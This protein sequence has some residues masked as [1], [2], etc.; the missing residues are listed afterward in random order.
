MTNVSN[1]I[2]PVTFYK[3]SKI[4][5]SHKRFV[6]DKIPTLH[7]K[8]GM[9]SKVLFERGSLKIT[10]SKIAA[11]GVE[12][13][14]NDTVWGAKGFKY[15]QLH[16]K[17]RIH[18]LKHPYHFSLNHGNRLL[19]NI[20]LD[21]RLAWM[22]KNRVNAYYIRY[23]AFRQQ[24][25][26][27]QETPKA[28]SKAGKLKGLLLNQM[29]SCPADSE[30]NYEED[31]TLPAITYGFVDGKN[32]RSFNQGGEFGF[33]TIRYFKPVVFFRYKPVSLKGVR[34]ITPREK[35]LIKQLVTASYA[36][37]NLVHFN[38][39]F[40]D[41]H[42]HI[43]EYK[44]EIFAGCQVHKHYWKVSGLMGNVIDPLLF[45]LLRKTGLKKYFNPENFTFLSF[46]HLFVKPGFEHVFFGL[47]ESL[48]A[49]Y[50][51]HMAMIP[52]DAEDPMQSHLN[53]PQKLG[54]AHKLLKFK[55]G[56]VLAKGLDD[57]KLP[58]GLTE[59]PIFISGFDI[60]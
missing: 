38:Y 52:L 59:K 57:Y 45:P 49:K 33:E 29:A 32:A 15:N 31:T 50:N 30:I 4:C 13:L 26:A 6:P 20:T 40:H 24:I 2:K 18:K 3:A 11:L 9:K 7:A 22:G 5:E 10:K 12:N 54:M 19:G 47:F 39:L 36:N 41:N 44:G 35:P 25:Q 56:Y 28:H 58:K 14:L 17:E 42:Y 16:A 34:T 1:E 23:F 55:P 51:A 53:K 37:H 46:D 48:L 60:T 27:K 8:M 43:L 21:H